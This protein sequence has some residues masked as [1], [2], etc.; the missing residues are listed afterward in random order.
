MV[1]VV[2]KCVVK[3][4]IVTGPSKHLPVFL[5]GKGPKKCKT[6]VFDHNWE[7]GGSA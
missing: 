7:G 3:F 5:L 4:K 6:M 2:V 1:K